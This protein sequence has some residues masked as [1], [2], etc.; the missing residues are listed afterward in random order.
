MTLLDDCLAQA[1]TCCF[2]NSSRLD[3]LEY[4]GEG[5]SRWAQYENISAYLGTTKLGDRGRSSPMTDHPAHR[6]D[7]N[8]ARCHLRLFFISATIGDDGHHTHV[9]PSLLQLLHEE[10]NLSAKFIIDLFDTEDW[11][12]FPT[13]FTFSRVGEVPMESALQYGCWDWSEQATH[14][15]VQLVVD[16]DTMTYYFVNFNRELKQFV[17]RCLENLTGPRVAPLFL[18][19]QILT[20][21]LTSYRRGLAAQRSKLRQIESREDGPMDRDQVKELH[22]LCRV[23]QVML[24]DFADLQE[25]TGQ[26]KTFARRL[27]TTYY[28]ASPDRRD[29]VLETIDLLAQFEN[30]CTFWMNWARTYLDRTNICINL[31]HQLQNKEIALQA[32][33]ESISMFT[34]AIVTVIFLP[35][36]F[37]ASILGTNFFN[38]DGTVFAVSSLWWILPVTSIPLTL[39]VLLLWYEWSKVRLDK[40]QGQPQ[41]GPLERK[42]RAVP[43]ALRQ[44]REL[45]Q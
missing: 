3:V 11:T 2:K 41:G 22:G 43:S 16:S 5:K 13:S 8:E 34:L 36:T 18:D 25:H 42:R 27:N 35:S 40:R 21:L 24:K 1:R 28:S 29:E 44:L 15:F 38:F 10:G 4:T 7:G 23:L 14:S 6:E 39:V 37:V 26:L 32:R 30:S 33:R 9:D 19:V 31:A 45:M 12:L 17:E 20:H